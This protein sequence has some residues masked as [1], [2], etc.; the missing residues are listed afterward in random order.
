MR[1][2]FYVHL[3]A[4]FVTLKKNKTK[5]LYNLQCHVTMWSEWSPCSASCG[6]GRR[7]RSRFFLG[8]GTMPPKRCQLEQWS[9][10]MLRDCHV[11]MDSAK[12]ELLKLIF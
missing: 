11:T 8:P 5:L 2:I 7:G 9:P 10:C 6:E 4:F 1:T 3:A 12:G